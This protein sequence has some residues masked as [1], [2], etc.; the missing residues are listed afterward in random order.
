[1]TDPIAEKAHAYRNF[2]D[3][4]RLLPLLILSLLSALTGLLLAK[5]LRATI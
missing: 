5:C 3:S 2:L 4:I 1:M